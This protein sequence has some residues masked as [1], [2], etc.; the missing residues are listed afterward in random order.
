MLRY[1]IPAHTTL[2][3]HTH[4]VPNIAY[5]VSGEITVE[6]QDSGEK[7]LFKAGEAMAEVVNS[8]HRGY[9]GE[10]AAEL[11]V[12]YAGAAGLPLVIKQSEAK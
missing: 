5:I 10:Q 4:V 1:S 11:V 12:F 9:T 3:W 2:P 7:R 8:T 6:K